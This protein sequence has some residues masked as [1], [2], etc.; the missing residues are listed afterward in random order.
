MVDS[1]LRLLPLEGTNR[2]WNKKGET[3]SE[4]LGIALLPG[5]LLWLWTQARAGKARLQDVVQQEGQAS[6]AAW[7]VRPFQR[8]SEKN[9]TDYTWWLRA[10]S[11]LKT[12]HPQAPP[13]LLWSKLVAS[14][15]RK[16]LPENTPGVWEMPVSNPREGQ[17]WT[18]S[19]PLHLPF[20]L[21]LPVLTQGWG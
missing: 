9:S 18:P 1:T 2:I 5:I 11:P 21:M 6:H 15:Q 20:L 3:F 19:A 7:V 14:D 16:L 10:K 8:C 17:N 13:Q 4:C 12:P